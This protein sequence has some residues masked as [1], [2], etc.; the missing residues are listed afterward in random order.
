MAYTVLAHVAPGDLATS[1][2]ENAM[3]DNFAILKTPITDT[4]H[5]RDSGV[6]TVTANYTVSVSD[7]FVACHSATGITITLPASSLVALRRITVKNWFTG[8]VTMATTGGEF[9]DAA[10]PSL[11]VLYQN[12]CLTF[13]SFGTGWFIV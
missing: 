6:A 7:D 2:I 9:I 3:I 5:L 12:D 13:W 8:P 10:S 4:G 11:A 1:A